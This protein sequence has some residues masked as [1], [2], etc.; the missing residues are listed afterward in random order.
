MFSVDCSSLKHLLVSLMESLRF[1]SFSARLAD[2]HDI[3][4]SLNS[5][6]VA[7]FSEMLP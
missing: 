2:K 4:N 5:I 3:K 6:D 7:N 1:A